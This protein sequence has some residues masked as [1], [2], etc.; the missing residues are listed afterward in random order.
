MTVAGDILYTGV[1]RDTSDRRLKASIHQLP[2]SLEA[3]LRLKPVSFSMNEKAARTE[4]DLIAQDVE[5]VFPAL[6]ST[7]SDPSGTKSLNYIGLIAPTIKAV[8][9]LK[10]DNDN[11]RSEVDR[12]RREL[13]DLKSGV[14]WRRTGTRRRWRGACVVTDLLTAGR[15]VV[16]DDSP[17]SSRRR[18]RAGRDVAYT[19]NS[20]FASAH[21]AP[22][23]RGTSVL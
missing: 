6:V 3:M 20:T 12:L 18:Q 11:L 9:E 13:R 17:G 23:C 16:T 22:T 1:V 8:Q 2:S 10:A 5:G 15:R 21:R 19:W 14:G 7:A 4:Y